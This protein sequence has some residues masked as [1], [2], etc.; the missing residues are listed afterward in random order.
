MS[1]KHY[2]SLCSLVSSVSVGLPG[3]LLFIVLLL[4]P[5]QAYAQTTCA[6]AWSSTSIYTG[7]MTASIG[8]VN[9]TANFWTQGQDPRSNSGGP[10]S[11]QP[12]TSNGPCSGSGTGGGSGSCASPW[13]SSAVYTG[14][15][16]A[17]LNGVNYKANFW[18]QEQ[19]P[20]TNNGGAGSG[21]PWTVTGICA[22]C[23]LP[24]LA[25]TGL[26]ASSITACGV[27][28]G[29][30]AVSA[31]IDCTLTGYTVFENGGSIGSTNG[32]SFSVSGLSP[33][34]SYTFAVTANDSVGSSNASTAITVTTQAGSCTVSSGGKMFAPYVDLGLTADWQLLSIQQQSGIKDFTLGFIVAGGSGCT[35]VWGGSGVSV[36]NDTLPNG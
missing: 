17:S 6:T 14:G 8:G 2:V 12:W 3:F 18:T 1:D 31:P 33:S 19:N 10:G 4:M 29:W 35:P 15:M 30:T 23:S 11:G 22:V 20:A 32:T 13:S 16:T 34:T 25:P 27:T 26:S 7:G 36:A 9:Y 5:F 21:A 24:P 28:L